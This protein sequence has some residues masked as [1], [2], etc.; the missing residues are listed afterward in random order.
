MELHENSAEGLPPVKTRV[1]LGKEDLS[2][3]VNGHD[4]FDTFEVYVSKIDFT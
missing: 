1:T 4:I 3:K 2:V